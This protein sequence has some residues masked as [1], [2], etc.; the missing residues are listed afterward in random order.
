MEE[1][2]NPFSREFV[3]KARAFEC[4]G[5]IEDAKWGTKKKY[6]TGEEQKAMV[7]TIRPTNYAGDNMEQIYVYDDRRNGRWINFVDS[8]NNVMDEAK[9]SFN[10]KSPE[11]LVGHEFR[12]RRTEINRW[13]GDDD[14]EKT[15]SCLLPTKYIGKAGSA[16]AA[17]AAA[18]AQQAPPV[19][20]ASAEERIYGLLKVLGSARRQVIIDQLKLPPMDAIKALGALT[21]AGRIKVV[22]D[23]YY[24]L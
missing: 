10:M 13:K 3:K 7:L 9:M 6:G 4:T 22:G 17:T 15:D 1:E 11:D 5:V 12:W 20:A 21:T 14:I 16:P 2:L 19:A 24:P 23:D 8:L 18:P